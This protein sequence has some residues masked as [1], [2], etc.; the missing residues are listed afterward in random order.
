MTRAWTKEETKKVLDQLLAQGCGRSKKVWRK[1]GLSDTRTLKQRLAVGAGSQL[2]TPAIRQQLPLC[3]HKALLCDSHI[4]LLKAEGKVFM[5]QLQQRAALADLL[6]AAGSGDATAKS[7]LSALTMVMKEGRLHWMFPWWGPED[8]HALLLYYHRHGVYLYR[9]NRVALQAWARDLL[10][11]SNIRI[12]FTVQV[13]FKLF[14]PYDTAYHSPKADK[15]P[16]ATVVYGEEQQKRFKAFLINQLTDLMEGLTN[17]AV[18]QDSEQERAFLKERNMLC[19]RSPRKEVSSSVSTGEACGREAVRVYQDL[20][21]AAAGQEVKV[22]CQHVQVL[23]LHPVT[24]PAKLIM[25]SK[26]HVDS[27]GSM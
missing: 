7:R 21:P 2:I 5:K 12:E 24:V 15:E 20:P 27:L 22:Y 14:A 8:N 16:K 6:G 13:E 3:V 1:A 17:P 11:A 10:E 18:I 9:Q 25:A 19:M 4:T 23:I 26:L